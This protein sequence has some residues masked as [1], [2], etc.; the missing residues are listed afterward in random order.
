MKL[1]K[2]LAA[3]LIGSAILSL[4]AFN[5]DV[6]LTQNQCYAISRSEVRKKQDRFEK[7][8]NDYEECKRVYETAVS[9]RNRNSSEV[10]DAREDLQDARDEYR[11]AKS[12]YERALRQ[13]ENYKR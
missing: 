4:P 2:I 10:R 13:Y 7:A 11:K 9:R 12:A 5:F 1:K 6:S 3:L 8:R